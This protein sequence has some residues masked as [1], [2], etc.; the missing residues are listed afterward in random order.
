[1]E[2]TQS[3]IDTLRILQELDRRRLQAQLALES[4]PQKQQA[5]QLREK[6]KGV[7]SKIA[8]VQKLYDDAKG[9]LVRLQTE[10]EKLVNKIAETQTAIDQAE[11]D[12]RSITALSRDMEGMQKRRETVKFESDKVEARIAEVDKV[13]RGACE[14]RDALI[15]QEEALAVSYRAEGGALKATAEEA[16]KQREP[17]VAQLSAELIAEYDRV[18]K[19]CAGI[20]LT[21]VEGGCC[22]VCRNTIDESRLLQMK[23]EAPLSHCPS[24]GRIAIMEGERA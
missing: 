8:Q 4:L 18:S 21:T 6:L 7:V 3:H 16:L 10:D 17:L 11:G 24:C 14:A 13:L 19:K 23:A 15:K 9:E 1:M 5:E 20:A 2:A 12:Y 22:S